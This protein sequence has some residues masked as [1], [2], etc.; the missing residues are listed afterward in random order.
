MIDMDKD[1]KKIKKLYGEK[2]MHLCRELFP[3]LL[4]DEG[5]LS[6]LIIDNFATN[7]FLY[8]DIVESKNIQ[9]FRDYIY[10][11]VDVEKIKK[12]QSNKTSKELLEEVGY[13]LY[14]CKT[15]EDI[16]SFKKYYA[17]GEELCT[18]YGGR[19]NSC[20]VFFAVKKM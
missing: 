14:E 4:E 10:S 2:M 20:H 13:D 5:L 19:L 11:L 16:Q 6:K 18:F 3:T 9:N 12:V 1:L 17:T 15:E 8:D 7:K